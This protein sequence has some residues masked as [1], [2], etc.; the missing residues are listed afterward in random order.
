MAKVLFHTNNAKFP[1]LSNTK[2]YLDIFNIQGVLRYRSFVV[3]HHSDLKDSINKFAVGR[4]I[5]IEKDFPIPY[6]TTFGY[7]IFVNL[8]KRRRHAQSDPAFW[9]V[10][11][12]HFLFHSIY[13]P[14]N[15]EM[16]LT[17]HT[18]HINIACFS[19]QLNKSFNII[20]LSTW[21][22]YIFSEYLYSILHRV[23]S[24]ASKGFGSVC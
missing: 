1:S 17:S 5:G 11:N 24:A 3:H 13:K 4:K 23:G 19:H 10:L 16:N 20:R 21:W 8:K 6:G 14:A 2:K 15:L 7:G 12:F 22:R 18:L 9:I